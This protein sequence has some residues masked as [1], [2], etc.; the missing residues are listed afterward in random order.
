MSAG[1]VLFVSWDMLAHECLYGIIEFI[2]Q[3]GAGRIEF[4][5]GVIVYLDR[6]IDIIDRSIEFVY[7]V[8]GA[9]GGFFVHI[10]FHLLEV[11]VL[12]QIVREYRHLVIGL[13][14]IEVQDVLIHRDQ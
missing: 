4:V 2:D 3:S 7:V 5:I 6:G 9:A 10:S 14:L 8:F 13:F 11:V 12:D 1:R